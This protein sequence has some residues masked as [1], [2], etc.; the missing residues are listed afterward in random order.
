MRDSRPV[1]P[2]FTLTCPPAD[3]PDREV[4]AIRARGNLPLI[5]D[6]NLLAEISRG[7]LFE[8]WETAARLPAAEIANY[9]R[10]AGERLAEVFADRADSAD[11]VDLVTDA[12]VLF[13]LTMRRHRVRTPDE[14]RPCTLFWDDEAREERLLIGA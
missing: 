1:A 12:A 4:A 3:S 5:I 14:I 13:L 9:S 8:S 2:A 6:G 10:I 7:D 11:L